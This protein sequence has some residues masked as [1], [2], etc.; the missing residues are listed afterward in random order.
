MHCW[1]QS[2]YI[3]TYINIKSVNKSVW[4]VWLR[5]EKLN[6]EKIAKLKKRKSDMVSNQ[7]V[8]YLK[9]MYFYLFSKIN[10]SCLQKT[11]NQLQTSG[12]TKYIA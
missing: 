8:I 2:A 1:S 12:A 6:P 4:L 11:K 9:Y 3:I 7:M 10:E 5:R